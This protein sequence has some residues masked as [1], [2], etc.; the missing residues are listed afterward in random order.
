MDEVE[1]DVEEVGLARGVDRTTCSSQTF[2]DRV[3][4][5]TISSTPTVVVT[6]L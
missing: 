6:V 2:S 1:V 5:M 4:P 3:L